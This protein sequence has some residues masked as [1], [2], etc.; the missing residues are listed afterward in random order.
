M[1]F[2]PPD[3]AQFLN[4]ASN[5]FLVRNGIPCQGPECPIC[6][7]EKDRKKCPCQ[8]TGPRDWS[9]RASKCVCKK[10]KPKLT[11]PM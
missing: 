6:E 11:F 7:S 2:R 9:P 3:Y 8:M 10:I 5:I 1:A 4:P